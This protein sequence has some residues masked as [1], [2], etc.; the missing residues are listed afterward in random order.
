MEFCIMIAQHQHVSGNARKRPFEYVDNI[1]LWKMMKKKSKSK[2]TFLEPKWNHVVEEASET[3]PQQNLYVPMRRNQKLSDKVTTLQKLV[4]PFGKTDT[5]SVLHE[6]SLHI[7][8]LQAQ[9]Q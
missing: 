3:T 8:L 5:A 6:A 2:I 9:I 7:K 1:S 4:S